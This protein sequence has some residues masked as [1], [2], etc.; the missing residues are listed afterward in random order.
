MKSLTENAQAQCAATAQ[1]VI[2]VLE[3]TGPQGT[4][5][6]ASRQALLPGITAAPELLSFTRRSTRKDWQ[7]L[8]GGIIGE[9]MDCTILW[10][11]DSAICPA[12]WPVQ[13]RMLFMNDAATAEDWIT[14]FT[15][16][17]QTHVIR[18]N[19]LI[20]HCID[21]LRQTLARNIE[22]ATPTQWLFGRVADVA[23]APMQVLAHA[24]LR[25]PMDMA[26][27]VAAL[28]SIDE[29]PTAGLAQIGG[30]II[31]YEE[32]DE[33]A[34]TLG[35]LSHP[36]TRQTPQEHVPGE[37]ARFLPQE[38]LCFV[39]ADHPCLA[40]DELRA[41][42]QP[43]SSNDY[44]VECAERDGRSVQIV[45]LGAWPM[46]SNDLGTQLVQSSELRA[47]VQ[48]FM[49]NGAL[50]E[51][52]AEVLRMLLTHEQFGAMDEALLQ[53]SSFE[54]WGAALQSH[55]YGAAL[56]LD[57]SEVLEDIVQFL[58]RECG[59]MI[60]VAGGSIRVVNLL[61]DSIATASLVD[62]A[63]LEWRAIQGA[64]PANAR[65]QG[66]E[67][68]GMQATIAAPAPLRIEHRT[69]RAIQPVPEPVQQLAQDL[70]AA[71]HV[72]SQTQDIECPLGGIAY[73]PGDT[74]LIGEEEV[75]IAAVEQSVF[76]RLTLHVA[77]PAQR[78]IVW[79]DPMARLELATDFSQ[80]LFIIED[81]IVARLMR[82]GDL[83]LTGNVVSNA[84]AECPIDQPI[85]F[86]VDEDAILF[87]A[88]TEGEWHAL[89][90][91]RRNGDLLARGAFAQ[92]ASIQGTMQCWH[93]YDDNSVRLSTG[94][95]IPLLSHDRLA[96]SISQGGS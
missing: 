33:A 79:S 68:A 40:V 22:R 25:L 55:D 45:R 54:T 63:M 53:S 87:G 66:I 38:G 74:L 57:R 69:L 52:P 24:R 76:H 64:M 59:A 70:L 8:P 48:G 81:Q 36:I 73:E 82:N 35:T 88:G 1:D 80:L 11:N 84:L 47:D 7:K 28:N 18:A 32:V 4:T 58:L 90:G 43:V 95:S 42:G 5:R 91:V 62:E 27:P 39:V 3:L 17:V 77:R 85:V 65:V 31:S 30:E 50:L 16:V 46:V 49:Q 83:R 51:N 72:Q 61:N 56:V 94:L 41:S 78:F 15:G 89:L 9:A 75:R 96:G 10:A 60:V 93:E 29:F 37:D 71:C 34:R 21:P 6:H 23:L 2:Y 26:S 14:L 67:L 44:T 20:L 19:Q 92:N 12:G 13:L 86:H